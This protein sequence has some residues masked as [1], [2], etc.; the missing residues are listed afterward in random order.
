MQLASCSFYARC[1]CMRPKRATI[2]LPVD[3]TIQG[4]QVTATT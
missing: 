4:Q 3:L 1:G 2:S